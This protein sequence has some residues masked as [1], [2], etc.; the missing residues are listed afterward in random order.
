MRLYNDKK[1]RHSS[2]SEI[3]Q[4]LSAAVY[5]MCI[6]VFRKNSRRLI[7]YY[8]GVSE[9][10]VR[11]FEEQTKYL[12]Q[13]C[14]VVKA[15]EIIGLKTGRGRMVA[16][17][18]DDAFVSVFKNAVPV[19]KKYGLTAS[20]AVPTGNLGQKPKWPVD[21]ANESVMTQE[22]VL[23]LD[24]DGFEVFSHT[25]TH[26][27]LSGIKDGELRDELANSKKQLEDILCH[28]V[29]GI[30]Y[31]HGDYDTRV[32]ES[33]RQAGYKLGFTIEPKMIEQDTDPIEMGRFSVSPGDGLLKFK[34]KVSG[35]YQITA[36]LRSI[37]ARL[38]GRVG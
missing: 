7:I 31:P 16:I 30:C 13:K 24:R 1:Q 12:A 15:S 17:T 33:A 38:L 6:A 36:Y 4:F 29:V 32:C 37:K 26:R 27:A 20:I 8:H 19:L 2:V 11:E 28:E 34:L 21:E 18:F 5:W 25:V 9:R 3:M 23:E 35:A 14:N 22:Q 10:H